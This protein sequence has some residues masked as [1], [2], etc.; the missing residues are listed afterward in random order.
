DG[1]AFRALATSVVHAELIDGEPVV[2]AEGGSR[3]RL[4]MPLTHSS[5]GPQCVRVEVFD[6]QLLPVLDEAFCPTEW[7]PSRPTVEHTFS[8]TLRELPSPPVQSD[9]RA[10]TCGALTS[11][12]PKRGAPSGLAFAAALVWLGARRRRRATRTRGDQAVG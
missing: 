10:L 5:N 8:T 2:T 1:T 4:W 11:G 7:D 9:A 12:A 6:E 3:A